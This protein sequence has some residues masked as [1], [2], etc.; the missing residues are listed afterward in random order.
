MPPL[1]DPPL[2]RFSAAAD[3]E[4]ELVVVVL[5]VGVEHNERFLAIDEL[6]LGKRTTN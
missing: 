2:V 4:E 6:L 1:D 5:S 3:D